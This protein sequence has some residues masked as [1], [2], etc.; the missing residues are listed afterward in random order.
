MQAGYAVGL[1]FLCPLGDLFK[2]RPFV[3]LLVLFTA[4][5]WI[6]LCLTKSF[7]VFSAISFL[8]AITTVTPQLMLPLVG[9]LARPNRRA[10]AL[11]VV[12]AGLMLGLLMARLLSGVL[13]NFT[14]WRTIYWLSLGLQ[15]FIFFLLWLFM[16][17]YPSTNPGGLNY[18][19]MLWSIL[20]LVRKNPV[21]VQ[22]CLITLM[23]SATFTCFWT[24]LTFLLSSPPYNYDSL[25]IGLFALIGIAAMFTCPLWARHVIDRFVPLF[26]VILGELWCLLG[27]CIGTYAG[28][29]TV[30]G[31]ILQA[32]FNDFGLQ[33]AQIANRSS[34]FSIAP[35]ARNRVNTAFMVATFCGQLIGT[36]A[37]NHLYARGGW[38]ASG[39]YSVASIGVALIFCVI[40]GPW[41]EGW[42]GWGGGWSIRKRDRASADGKGDGGVVPSPG[43]EVNKDLGGSGG[44]VEHGHGQGQD[45]INQADP[46]KALEM[47]AAEDGENPVREMNEKEDDVEGKSQS[48][49]SGDGFA[50]I[51]GADQQQQQQQQT[52]TLK[53]AVG[54]T[55][56]GAA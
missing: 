54:P 25:L 49:S 42:I 55:A 2:R 4:T 21:L 23:T 10:A 3:L 19:K 38:V 29:H 56:A 12:A 45:A 37:G 40:R 46:E 11:S 15:Y 47:D 26:S 31:P 17:D 30:A 34:I 32:F 20:V 13:T 22:A 6:G 8:T 33:S 7:Q 48:S 16:P 18:F 39:S 14:S 24:T 27:I 36:A 43:A 28:K 41:E 51:N 52:S 9:D 35:K 53:H 1:L 50:G 44:D 5:L